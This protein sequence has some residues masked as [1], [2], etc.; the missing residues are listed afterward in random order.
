MASKRISRRVVLV[1]S[2]AGVGAAAIG[3]AF[4]VQGI[5]RSNA[6]PKLVEPQIL[7]SENGLLEVTL[8]AGQVSHT[9]SGQ[10]YTMFGYN[11]GVPGPTLVVKSGD[12]VRVKLQNRLNQ[13][14]N[15]HTHG[16]HVSPVGNSDNPMIMVEPGQ[17]FDY[18][19]KIPRNH[20]NGTYWYHPHHHGQVAN[21]TWAGLYGAI[22]VDDGLNIA[23]TKRVMII[24]DVSFTTDGYV[25]GANMMSRMMGREGDHLL[26]NGQLHPVTEHKSGQAQIW[27]IVNACVSRN[28]S[29]RISGSR[30]NVIAVDGHGVASYSAAENQLLS[31][32]NRID[33][34]VEPGGGDVQLLYTTV[35]H[36][37]SM[38]MMGS[39]AKTYTD[40]PLITS[41][42]NGTVT[43]DMSG[44]TQGLEPDL[45]HMY[46][47]AKR[48]FVLNMPSMNN[49]MGM[50]GSG[51]EGRF[52][53]NGQAFDANRIDTA[54]KL[55][56]I[57]EWTIVNKSTMAHPFHLHVWPMQVL[58]VGG[59][60]V[61]HTRY[62]DVVN[63]PAKQSAVVRVMFAD[64]TGP[65]VYHCHILDH[66]DLGMMGI[67]E[68]S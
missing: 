48:E 36:P 66:E 32:G 2:G 7:K 33:V 57:E 8:T 46:V 27:H 40:Y 42:A 1:A 49:M 41:R 12:T 3:G 22:I 38:G 67:I 44:A 30:A 56:A 47:N 50:M 14:T 55:G 29:L 5:Q 58:R 20:P 19:Y 34:M 35:A 17:D 31:P 64:Y 63:V 52:T 16:L 24:S 59:V 13:T 39:S 25:A 18:E 60:E 15:L 26:L 54:T 23:H 45:R 21:Q 43:R 61:G 28:L 62:Q 65:S 9:I 4:A 6:G 68:V 10:S 11:G 51:L 53:I 37:D